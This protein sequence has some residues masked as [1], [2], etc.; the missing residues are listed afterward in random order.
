[1]EQKMQRVRISSVHDYNSLF[2]IGTRHPLV[3]VVDLKKATK[4]VNHVVMDYGVYALFLKNGTNCTLKYG[5]REYDCQEGTVVS[6]SPGQVVG[7]D[8]DTVE[9]APDVLGLV[10]HPDIIFDTPLGANIGKYTFFDYSQMESLHLSQDERQ[11]FVDCLEKIRLETEHPVDRHSASLISSNIQLLLDYLYRFYDRQFITRH[12]VN[13]DIIREFEEALRRFFEGGECRKG[14]ATVAY[15]ADK[16]NLSAGYFGDLVKKETGVNAK[17]FIANYMMRIAKHR[18]LATDEDIATIA[19]DLG[20]QYPQHFT[21]QFKRITGL[22]PTEFR[23]T[24]PN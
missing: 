5:R 4:A 15:F 20:F 17:D 18:L 7:V 1:M 10:F 2:G 16:A 6:F 3:S 12:R 19:Y 21:R 24:S 14:L 8:M 11:L 9:I 13:S 23:E 22:S